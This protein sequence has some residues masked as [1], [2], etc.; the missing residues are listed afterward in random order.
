MKITENHIR[1]TLDYQINIFN[2]DLERYE[3]FLDYADVL[4][5]KSSFEPLFNDDYSNEIEWCINEAFFTLDETPPIKLEYNKAKSIIYAKKAK[6]YIREDHYQFTKYLELSR[7][8][9]SENLNILFLEAERLS[10]NNFVINKKYDFRVEKIYRL[11]L[12]KQPLEIHALEA[13]GRIQFAKGEFE[14]ALNSFQQIKNW[15]VYGEIISLIGI[16]LYK[17]EKQNEGLKLCY[18]ASKKGSPLGLLYIIQLLLSEKNILKQQIQQAFHLYRLVSYNLTLQIIKTSNETQLIL[19]EVLFK[20]F[21]IKTSYI[22]EWKLNSA[23][24]RAKNSNNN[25]FKVGFITNKYE[26]SS[27]FIGALNEVNFSKNTFFGRDR[28]LEV[29]KKISLN[30]VGLNLANI[31][32]LIQEI[33]DIKSIDNIDNDFKN[34]IKK[35]FDC[36]L[37]IQFL[38]LNYD[39]S[40]CI[41]NVFFEEYDIRSFTIDEY[42]NHFLTDLLKKNNE[43]NF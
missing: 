41:K 6:L 19:D 5:Y 12:E 43:E 13:I 27:F 4:A 30:S 25:N 7:N 38:N 29:E 23:I 26:I 36:G 33:Q 28:H 35:A 24:I 3:R 20:L 16:T 1:E 10:L 21:G 37:G 2:Q 42:V 8:Y 31:T 11:I 9:W 18:D 17:L 40:I 15:E 34:Q 39:F 22:I 32:K 14:A